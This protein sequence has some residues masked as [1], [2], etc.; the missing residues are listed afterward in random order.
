VGIVRLSEASRGILSAVDR[1]WPSLRLA[2]DVHDWRWSQIAADT[3]ER[4]AIVSSRGPSLLWCSRSERLLALPGGD[5]Y[6]LS[7]IEANPI[8]RGGTALGAF[9]LALVGSRALECGAHRLVLAAIPPL[10]SWYEA[11][12]GTYQPKIRGWKVPTELLPFEFS[13]QRL[14]EFKEFTDAFLEGSQNS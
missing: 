13:G 3:R 14:A 6:H 5:A 7:F 11:A 8:F 2:S 4:F 12:G 9:G 10:R 1:D